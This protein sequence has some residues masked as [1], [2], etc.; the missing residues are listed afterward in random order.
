MTDSQDFVNVDPG[1]VKPATEP[2]A[3][4]PLLSTSEENTLAMIA[5]L[6]ILLNLVT[7][8]LGCAGNLSC[9]QRPLTLCGVPEPS[10]DYFPTGVLLWGCHPGWCCCSC[11]HPTG[12]RLHRS[13]W[14]GPGPPPGT[15]ADRRAHLRHRRCS[16]N[17]S[18][19]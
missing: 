1:D 12:S 7:G 15:G 19:S 16:G 10:G 13:F 11:F 14:S 4:Q 17:Q 9:L 3:S 18:W 8:I 5:H 2:K 6:S